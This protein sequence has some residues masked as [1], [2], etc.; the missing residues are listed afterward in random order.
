MSKFLA[1][2]VMM[3]SNERGEIVLSFIVKG[4]DKQ[5]AI[6]ACHEM[7]GYNKK[8]EISA[9]EYRSQRSIEQ[10]KMM[11]ALLGKLCEAM[12]G[13]RKEEDMNKLYCD[14]LTECN[15]KSEMILALNRSGERS[16]KENYRAVR[17][18][19]YQT[20]DGF[21]CPL[22]QCFE[23]SSKFDTKE[24]TTMIEMILNNLAELGIYD[25][26]IEVARREYL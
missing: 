26:E 14:T 16:L 13:Y 5:A 23:G 1:E 25:S 6:T 18:V 10:N 11:W 20:V 24:M 3:R 7:L 9:K 17:K 21:Q 19:G 12:T 4:M 8:I 2:S 15:I 22:Y